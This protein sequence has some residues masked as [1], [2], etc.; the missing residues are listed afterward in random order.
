MRLGLRRVD[1]D[2]LA[3]MTAARMLQVVSCLALVPRMPSLT[4]DLA[5]SLELW[6]QLPFAGGLTA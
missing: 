2:V 3:V 1:H 4:R 6:R 5:P